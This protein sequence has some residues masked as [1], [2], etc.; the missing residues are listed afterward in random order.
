[1]EGTEV[2]WFLGLLAAI[3]TFGTLQFFLFWGVVVLLIAGGPVRL[4][5]E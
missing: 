1:M 4:E 2:G 3:L 5:E